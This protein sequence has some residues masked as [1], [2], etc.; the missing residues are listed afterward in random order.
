MSKTTENRVRRKACRMGYAVHKS[1][2]RESLDN[3]GAFMLV[4]ERNFVCLGTRFDA[5]LEDIEHWL[6]QPDEEA[7]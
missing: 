7:A 4:D 1:R 3:Y 5:S 6:D 2:A